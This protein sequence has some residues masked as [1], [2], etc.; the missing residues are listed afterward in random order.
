MLTADA[1]RPT[2]GS[3]MKRHTRVM[4]AAGA[5]AGSVLGFASPVTA[6]PTNVGSAQDTIN[7]LQGLGYNVQLNGTKSAPLSDCKVI[8][9]WP[10]DPGTA[11]P[12]H[13]TTIWV[14]ISCPP[15]NN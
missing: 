9:V 14:D 5:I 1:A 15:T 13:F 2:K 11:A 10:G 7:R 8:G 6:A 12:T 3:T 4:A